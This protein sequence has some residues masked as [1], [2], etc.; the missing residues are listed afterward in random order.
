MIIPVRIPRELVQDH[1]ID[2][3]V[4]I[5]QPLYCRQVLAIQRHQLSIGSE[6]SC[7]GHRRIALLLVDLDHVVV[8]FLAAE[9]RFAEVLVDPFGE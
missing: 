7:I 6:A 5:Q 8:I 9:V 3:L 2:E 1:K 4:D